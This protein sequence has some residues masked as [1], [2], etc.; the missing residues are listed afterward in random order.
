MRERPNFRL[1]FISLVLCSSAL[2]QIFPHNEIQFV[3][4]RPGNNVSENSITCFLQ[5][6][7]GFMWIGTKGGLY[8]YD[9][10]EF[11]SFEMEPLN[12]N[13]LN[14]SYIRCMIEYS[15]DELLLIGTN[16]GGL[17]I[18][19][20]KTGQFSHFT[21]EESDPNSIGSNT[22]FDILEDEAGR[23]WIA[24]IGGGLNCFDVETKVFKK[25]FIDAD[26]PESKRGNEIKCLY[27]DEA[28]GLWVGTRSLGLHLFDR[29]N[30][31]FVGIFKET[32]D[33]T[34]MAMDDI[35]SITKDHAGH[36]W[37]GTEWNQIFRL[38][39]DNANIYRVERIGRAYG[40][41]RRAVLKV[42]CDS[43]GT[44]WAGTWV[45]GLFKFHHETN[46]FTGYR[47][48]DNKLHGLSGNHV[49]TI[50]ED[51]AGSL[52]IGTHGGGISI[53]QP[54]KWKF[55]PCQYVDIEDNRVQ[56]DEVRSI[57][58]QEHT[59]TLWLGTPQGLSKIDTKT[60]KNALYT[61]ISGN[62]KGLLHNAVNCII[63][64]KDPNSIWIGTP[65]GLTRLNTRTEEFHHYKPSM[66]DSTAPDNINILK[67]IT[68][69]EGIIWMATSRIG[70]I[71]FD[72]A[73]Q[74][75]RTFG[76]ES[77]DHSSI[78]H[79][80]VRTVYDDIHG[81]LYVGTSKGVEIFDRRKEMFTP[82]SND[83]HLTTL[84]HAGI[85][86]IHR[87]LQNQLWIGTTG[88]G[89]IKYDEKTGHFESFTKRDGLTSNHICGIMEDKNGSLFMSTDNGIS[90]WDPVKEGFISYGV[91]D[92]LHGTEFQENACCKTKN[93]FMYYGG[94][95]GF[96]TFI[97]ER[98]GNNNCIPPV[99]I[100]QF[101][102][103]DS[104]YHS[105]ENILY[106]SSVELN[107]KMNSF[108]IE[109]VALNFINSQ[110]NQ[111][112]YKLEG[113]DEKWQEA[114]S[115]RNVVY[116]NVS[117]GNYT[118]RVM[119]SN[120]DGIW[121]EE[122]D[123]LS[124]YIKPP[125]WQTVSFKVAVFCLAIGIG[126]IFLKRR[127]V[128]LKKESEIRRR[129]THALIKNQEVERKRIASEL[130]DSL[131]QDL[132]VIKNRTNLVLRKEK[133]LRKETGQLDE[134]CTVAD[135]AIRNI[136]QI[137]YNLH[138]YQL[139]KLGLTDALKSMINKIDKS[140]N[141]L[142]ECDIK[143]INGLL[144][145]DQEINF[146]RVLQEL[147]NNIIKHSQ[148]MKAWVKIVPSK[149]CIIMHV[150]D[151]GIGFDYENVRNEQRGIGLSGVRERI[152]ILKGKMEIESTMNAG[153][154]FVIEIPI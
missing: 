98:M 109:F 44:I 2:S 9:G 20:K 18:Y 10:Y 103:F 131:G 100:T 11:T 43:K 138:P 30:E 132:L 133:N 35:W 62:E 89:L 95:N 60:G 22:V 15:R 77:D 76:K 105:E 6:R 126:A 147:L 110:N 28:D 63:Q 26:G 5:D 41:N 154:N 115:H 71:R 54:E 118:F 65:L 144:P 130:H 107:Y 146:Y 29:N 59:H 33:P 31:T 106:R 56:L 111:Y 116:R 21:H 3:H 124:I 96:T 23:I 97:P 83:Q 42:Y 152:E 7:H 140:S 88:F 52:W 8:R 32:D 24:T 86:V 81:K 149:K 25:Y 50:Y 13:S 84:L 19:N 104:Q 70:L 4:L 93:G 14:N 150:K 34:N 135:E 145:K 153:A 121:N 78:T 134:I 91:C 129:F 148:A 82:F 38:K 48:G 87:D 127:F 117:P 73:V 120:N 142:F 51:R 108:S 61:K 123:A 75:F 139:D 16:N 47:E 36:L 80:Y 102:V 17:N 55:N 151:D 69:R 40:L 136:R 57:H 79:W 1:L 64:G 114:G 68:D 12:D 113:Y 85:A 125:F 112:L 66:M 128:L 101:E 143:D 49:L 74:K 39:K 37:I 119:G 90:R 137:S 46:R 122:G 27:L 67:I 94:N 53:I 72:P 45:G 58:Y 92:G 141:I 99:H